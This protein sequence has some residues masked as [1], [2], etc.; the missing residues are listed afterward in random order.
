MSPCRFCTCDTTLM[1]RCHG[2]MCHDLHNLTVSLNKIN[3]FSHC[4]GIEIWW[5]DNFLVILLCK[6]MREKEQRDSPAGVANRAL[7]R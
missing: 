6:R 4:R 5:C 1:S 7:M 2:V 3:G